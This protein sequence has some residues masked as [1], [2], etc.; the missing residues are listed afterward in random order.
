MFKKFSTSSENV[1][2]VVNPPRKPKVIS[3]YILLLY[4]VSVLLVFFVK[5]ANTQPIKKLP[6]TFTKIVGLI[7]P[8]I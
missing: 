6:I 3:K 1:E 7:K 2:N 4:T 5:Y 8:N